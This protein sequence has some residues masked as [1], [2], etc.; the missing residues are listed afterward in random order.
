MLALGFGVILQT[1]LKAVLVVGI[2]LGAAYALTTYVALPGFVD[3]LIWIAAGGYSL[4]TIT[5]AIIALAALAVI[6]SAKKSG[7]L[8]APRT[9]RLH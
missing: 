6:A 1:L 5:G 3:V 7:Q 2:A 9:R 4:L 8:S